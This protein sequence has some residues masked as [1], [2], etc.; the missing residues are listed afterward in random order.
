MESRVATLSIFIKERKKGVDVNRILAEYSDI[1]LSRTGL[2][3]RE[4]KSFVI[5]LILDGTNDEIGALSGK[6][7]NLSGVSVKTA[8]AK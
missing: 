8:M 4:K 7:G 1:I 3:Y 2:P 5:V 6:I